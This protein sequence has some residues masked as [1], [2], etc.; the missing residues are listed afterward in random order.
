VIVYRIH[1]KFGIKMHRYT[2]L[3]CTEFQDIYFRL[4][5]DFVSVRKDE[6]KMEKFSQFLKAH[7]SGTP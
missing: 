6:E 4:I 3:T 5:A 2:L 1:D 7:I